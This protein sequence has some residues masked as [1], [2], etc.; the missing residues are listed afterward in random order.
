MARQATGK[1]GEDRAV[2]ALARRGYANAAVGKAYN[3]AV[4]A[5]KAAHPS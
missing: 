2:E 3:E 4:K 1:S 5:Y